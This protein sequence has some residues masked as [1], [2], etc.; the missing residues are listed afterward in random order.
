MTTQAPQDVKTYRRQLRRALDNAFLRQTLDTF[1]A[2][3]RESRARAFEGIDLE[4]LIADIA[5]RKASALPRLEEL[6]EEFKRRAE[7]AGAV[8]HSAATARE[9][10]ELIARIARENGVRTIIKS[11]SMTAEETFLNAHLEG[12]GFEVTETDL[13]EWIIQLRRE[14][15]SHMVLPAI[16]LSRHQVA[17]LFEKVTGERQDPDDI[18]KM[19]KVARR[20]LRRAY[21][22]ADMGISGANFA[23]AESGTLGLVT[24]EGNARLVTTLPRVHVALV[25]YDKLLPD[26]KPL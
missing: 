19:V 11:K 4:G 15:P 24:N 6:F 13:G 22:E 7:A 23:V 8:V 5:R 25:G 14:G 2:A 3:Y 18:E 20:T 17:E 1:A 10:N 16:H 9:A 12:E 26:W 21:L